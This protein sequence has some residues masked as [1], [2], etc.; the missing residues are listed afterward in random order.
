MTLPETPGPPAGREESEL[1]DLFDRFVEPPADARVTPFYWWSGSDLQRDRIA[2]H[3]ALLAA[4]GIG[5]TIVGYSHTPDGSVDHGSPTPFGDRWWDLFRSYVEQS[6]TLGMSAGIQD[7]GFIGPVLRRAGSRTAGLSAGTLTHHRATVSGP[8]MFRLDPGLRVVSAR[9]WRVEESLESAVP[10]TVSAEEGW[11]V[12]EG[13]WELSIVALDGK[14]IGIHSS[15]FDP[16]HPESG[17]AVIAEYYDLFIERLGDLVG[18]TLRTFFQDEL[19]FGL[20]MPMWND[21]VAAELRAEG[22]DPDIVVHALW[23]PFA[24]AERLRDAYRNIVRRLLEDSYFRPIFEWHEAHGTQLVMD[25]ISRGDLRLGHRHYADFLRTMRWYHGPGNDDPDL[26]APRNLA[27]FRVSASIARMFERPLVANEAFHSS[28]WGV[29]PAE[30]AAGADIG[31]AAGANMLILHGLNYTTNGGWWEWA[32][33]DFHFRQPW[34]D[35]SRPLWDYLARVCALLRE[36]TAVT[37]VCVVDPTPDLDLVGAGASSP[38][39]ARDV[40]TALTEAG[41]GVDLVPGDLLDA[42]PDAGLR[43][44]AATYRVAIT[45]AAETVSAAV[46]ALAAH[47]QAGGA[48]L[49]PERGDDLADLAR[50]IDAVQE[51]PLRFEVDGLRIAQRRVGSLDVFF[52]TNPLAHTVRTRFSVRDRGRTEIWDP[53]HGERRPVALNGDGTIATEAL[54]LPAGRSTVIVVD[55]SRPSR[56]ASPAPSPE[57]TELAVDAAWWTTLT[58]AVGPDAD[59]ADRETGVDVWEYETSPDAAGPWRLQRHGVAARL[60]AWGPVSA[61]TAA[62]VEETLRHS[63][64]AQDPASAP[65]SVWRE[66][67]FSEEAGI[68]QDP[69]LLDRM[70]GPHGLKGVPATFLDP[71]ALDDEPPPGSVY[72]FSARVDGDGDELPVRIRSRSA[73]KVW[74]DGACVIDVPETPAHRFPPWGLR[75]MSTPM[76]TRSVMV[77]PAARVLIRLDVS[78]EQPTRAAVVVGGEDHP[79]LAECR[80]EWWSGPRPALRFHLGQHD[81]P[82]PTWVRFV[83]PPGAIALL[84]EAQGVVVTARQGESALAVRPGDTDGLHRIAVTGEEAPVLVRI[85]RAGSGGDAFVSPPRWVPGATLGSLPGIVSPALANY[86]GAITSRATFTRPEGPWTRAEVVIPALAGSCAVV[87]NG[88]EAGSV[89]RPG[90]AVDVTAH[91]RPGVNALEL[92]MSNT[93]ANRYRRL[94]TPYG[95]ASSTG[96]EGVRILLSGAASEAQL[97]HRVEIVPDVADP[98]EADLAAGADG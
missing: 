29:T 19:D 51:R 75:D 65:G 47:E 9:A 84:I 67:A 13:H 77:P 35:D 46:A 41:I 59:L 22:M 53:W 7:Y 98:L 97:D 95:A 14:R 79:D 74:I 87:V 5:G 55:R 37:E 24:D 23:M 66:Y 6:A 60:R 58:P 38:E 34:W 70:A 28:T 69:F 80:L 26:A 1:D 32:S 30:I 89:L 76:T 18:T 78:A 4:K 39:R 42:D 17:A 48:V 57:G 10:V 92:R 68:F 45:V 27:A 56:P 54:E 63:V 52:V 86:S 62:D 3:L 21:R 50:A 25:Q 33:P 12:P 90:D 83:P 91:V 72:F 88:A 64:G 93:L 71:R 15:D 8:M 11:S 31:F 49:R 61:D 36:G 20:T 40:L 2:A 81:D 82:A 43:V 85:D 73:V 16:M 94:P 44:G 96:V